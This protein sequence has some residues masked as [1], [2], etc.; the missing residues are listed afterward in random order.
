MKQV[1]DNREVSINEDDNKSDEAS[2]WSKEFAPETLLD[3]D[4][5][6]NEWAKEHVQNNSLGIWSKNIR[7]HC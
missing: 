5:L 3:S 1:K 4:Q 7:K 6:A 2:N